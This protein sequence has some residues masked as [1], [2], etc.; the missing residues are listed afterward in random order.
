[1]GTAKKILL[2]IFLIS[3]VFVVLFWG[4]TLFRQHNQFSLGE[5]AL[6]RK[7]YSAA[8]SD[9]ASAIHM[10]TPGSSLVETAA[11]RLWSLGEGFEKARDTERALIAYRSLRS[12]CYAIRGLTNPGTKWITRCDGKLAKLTAKSSSPTKSSNP[13]QQF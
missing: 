9:Y 12:A 8:I 5:Q 11:S 6:A 2:H 10:Y 4:N 7:N 13:N 3:V 1:M